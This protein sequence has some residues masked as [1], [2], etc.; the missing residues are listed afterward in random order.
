MRA[1]DFE[2]PMGHIS[3]S[4]TWPGELEV[5]GGAAS[6]VAGHHRVVPVLGEK[7]ESF[8]ELLEAPTARQNSVQASV[9]SFRLVHDASLA[10]GLKAD[11]ARLKRLVS[12]WGVQDE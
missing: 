10:P 6:T 5:V 8:L 9:L 3:Q 2:K 4:Q 12:E 1:L 11:F 7:H